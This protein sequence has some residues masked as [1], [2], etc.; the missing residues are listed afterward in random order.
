MSSRFSDETIVFLS[1]NYQLLVAR[2]NLTFLK[3][4]FARQAK[5]RGKICWNFENKGATIRPIIQRH[6]HSI[7]I[8]FLS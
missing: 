7:A 3:Q 1:R 4:I 2:G 6:K 5:L 8:I